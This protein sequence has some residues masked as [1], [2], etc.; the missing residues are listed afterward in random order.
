[1]KILLLNTVQGL[2][3]MYDNDYEEKKKLKLGVVYTADIKIARNYEFLKKYFALINCAFEYLTLDIREKLFH[4]S[5][6]PFRK[7]LQ[8]AAGYCELVYS[9]ERKEFVEQAT[10]IAF[11][12]MT[13]AEFSDL[14]E[15]V[16]FV[17]FKYFLGGISEEAFMKELA[18]F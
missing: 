8:I 2:K 11:D 1:M 12:N 13:E 4:D 10:S 5:I 17:L 14:Y 6:E 3:P 18:N 16:K 9:V 7:T 15:K